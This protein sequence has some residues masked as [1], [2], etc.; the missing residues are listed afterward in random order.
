MIRAQNIRKVLGGREILK[1]LNFEVTP[2]EVIGFLGPNGAGKTT[3]LRILSCFY[4]PTSGKVWIGG[5][6]A[7]K[8]TQEIKTLL[9]YLPERVPLYGELTV[10]GYL[11][12][13]AEAKGLKGRKKRDQVSR[14]LERFGL[15]NRSPQI[16]KTL[17]KGFQKRVCLAQAAINDPQILLLD[18]P[19]NSLDPQQVVEVRQYIKELSSD[20]RTIL[21]SSHL[22]SEVKAVC[23]KIIVIDDGRIKA[24]E[25]IDEFG[26]LEN[27]YLD[28]IGESQEH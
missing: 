11:K 6:D 17:S 22:L 10:K 19:M 2:G 20:S 1:G 13:V 9:G 16:V 27:R 12:F 15:Q 3:T 5:L 25:T 4:Y 8:S 26:D 14:T 24:V 28:I 21:L 23:D 7:S 18:E